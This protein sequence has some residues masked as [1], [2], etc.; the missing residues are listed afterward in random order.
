MEERIYIG[1]LDPPLLTAR[2]VASRLDSIAGVHIRSKDLV[3][4]DKSFFYVNAVAEDGSALEKIAKLYNNVTWK[5]CKLVVRAARP[6]FLERL[7]QERLQLKGEE[8]PEQ[9]GEGN[10]HKIPRHLRIRQKFGEEAHHV[11]TKPCLAADWSGFCHA[12]EKMRERLEAHREKMKQT[13]QH[14]E[15]MALAKKA[16]Y[17][18]RSVHLRWKG[19]WNGNNGVPP[20]VDALE[21]SAAEE[22][23][24]T[25][26]SNGSSDQNDTDDDEISSTESSP[27]VNGKSYVWS[28]DES[29][30]SSED[31]S[32]NVIKERE[33]GHV[34]SEEPS[35]TGSKGREA[36]DDTDD[37]VSSSSNES[38]SSESEAQAKDSPSTP[39]EVNTDV[40]SSQDEGTSEDDEGPVSALKPKTLDFD[41]SDDDHD[42]SD[43]D[44]DHDDSDDDDDDSSSNERMDSTS[45]AADLFDDVK[46]NLGV[47]STLFPEMAK[48]TPRLSKCRNGTDKVADEN[49]HKLKSVRPGWEI[50]AASFGGIPSITAGL[51]V[52]QRFDPTKESA[53]KYII[54]PFA[55]PVEE[56]VVSE[57]QE[58]GDD[59]HSDKDDEEVEEKSASSEC[60]P[61]ESESDDFDAE[62]N[63]EEKRDA[64]Y[65]QNKL[66]DI[67]RQAR[68]SEGGDSFKLSSM[69]DGKITE[70]QHTAV[71]G[72]KNKPF[73]FGF[74]V[75]KVS[76]QSEQ[77][78]TQSGVFAFA[79][80]GQESNDGT[81][82]AK[83]SPNNDSK[84][85]YTNKMKVAE[86][87]KIKQVWT[88][89]CR[90]G[91]L[92]PEDVLNEYVDAFLSMNEGSRI[93]Q[94][95]QGFL[96]DEGV[97]RQWSKE[98]QTLTLDWKRKRKYAQ[99]RM[100]KKMKFR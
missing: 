2:E 28:D 60:S 31:H 93:V 56:G 38:M 59:H 46:S 71:T 86:G 85:D 91:L 94:D 49:G 35:A 66:E 5:R 90:P 75:G 11:D 55:P 12:V 47:L 8:A 65:E 43:G 54:E 53:K 39:E 61:G 100:Q 88:G 64:V 97:K 13:K 3:G 50:G 25:T 79:A 30:E 89:I 99:S 32:A 76:P 16:A 27:L 83:T 21:E 22:E 4:D 67:F 58:M 29:D 42:K 23:S 33:A 63:E 78:T 62:S 36:G 96:H 48:T 24:T 34:S 6:H 69:F 92:F 7:A 44:D 68:T 72:E 77:A 10:K 20:L 70:R 81:N 52:M 14:D 82:V 98:R 87:D 17:L 73:A 9:Q 41:D 19:T 51:E 26:D 15:K 45:G 57:D 18:N 80:T 95:P 37:L 74:D 1:G 84:S 40:D